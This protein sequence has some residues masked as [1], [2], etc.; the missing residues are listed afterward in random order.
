MSES[1]KALSLRSRFHFDLPNWRWAL[2]Y[3]ISVWRKPSRAISN[4]KLG[5]ALMVIVLV[6][7]GVQMIMLGVIGEYLWRTLE[8]ARNREIYHIE[9]SSL[10]ERK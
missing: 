7:G 3:S 4:P 10:K 5:L 1:A 6:F 9:E 8:Q 2:T